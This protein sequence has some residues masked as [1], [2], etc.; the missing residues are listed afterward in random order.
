ME[1]TSTRLNQQQPG[2]LLSLTGLSFSFE[3]RYHQQLILTKGFGRVVCRAEEKEGNLG[4]WLRKTKVIIITAI[5]NNVII[6][7][8]IIMDII[9]IR[10]NPTLSNRM[11]YYIDQHRLLACLQAKVVMMTFLCKL[12]PVQSSPRALLSAL[13]NGQFGPR[14]NCQWP[15][16]P[17]TLVVH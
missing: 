9:I 7:L 12:G 5:I 3:N 14:A 4:S 10:L 8:I 2:L 15:N 1:S 16:Y 13:K 6:N 11:F 17:Y